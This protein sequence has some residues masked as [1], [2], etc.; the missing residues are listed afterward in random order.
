MPF[1]K[2]NFPEYFRSGD[3]FRTLK[4]GDEVFVDYRHNLNTVK[5]I[6]LS[7]E[8]TFLL[9][10]VKGTVKLVSP[11]ESWEVPSNHLAL[12]RKG[13]YIM[14]ETLS[15]GDSQFSAFLFFLSDPMVEEFLNTTVP[16][17]GTIETRR[18][19]VCP[20]GYTNE[21]NLYLESIIL[22]LSGEKK[23]YSEEALL[24]VKARELLL[25]MMQTDEA[26][27]V[28]SVLSHSSDNEEARM[29]RVMNQNC[30]SAIT[31]EEL[32]FL[33]NMSISNFKRKF[34]KYFGVSP[35]KWI[36]DK[37]LD[38]GRHLLETT[39]RTVLE[40]ALAIGYKS[41]SH[42]IKEFKSRFGISPAQLKFRS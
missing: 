25:L 34:S 8:Q 33:N 35:G 40:V 27:G 11:D 20:I 19:Y 12:V 14:S 18:K 26:K 7:I 37:K 31:L 2:I 41:P 5:D 10:V 3:K 17:D 4:I 29:R 23:A 30:T 42:F 32:A 38:R 15:D 1:K 24:Q 36:K 9:Y 16:K 21:L 28:M 13:S 39:D 22:L 6:Q